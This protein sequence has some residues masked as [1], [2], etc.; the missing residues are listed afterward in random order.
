MKIQK[1]RWESAEGGGRKEVAEI[2]M[3][4]R[5]QPKTNK[6]RKENYITI[7]K[8][9]GGDTLLENTTGPPH[10]ALNPPF[11][12]SLFGG[13]GLSLFFFKTNKRKSCFPPKGHFGLFFSVSQCFCL[14]FFIPPFTLSSLSVLL[15]L[16]FSTLFFFSP[17]LFS[18]FLIYVSLFSS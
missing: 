15:S 9:K 14:S 17:S 2:G 1:W 8:Q 7:Q 4:Y 3:R 13:W 11:F 16:F 6:E 10:L 5:H 12:P 18:L